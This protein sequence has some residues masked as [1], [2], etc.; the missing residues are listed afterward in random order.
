MTNKLTTCPPWPMGKSALRKLG[1]KKYRQAMELF[2][3]E[4]SASIEDALKAG[5]NFHGLVH[6]SRVRTRDQDQ[7]IIGKAEELNILPVELQTADLKVMSGLTTP[8]PVIG[9]AIQLTDNKPSE[10]APGELVLALDRIN[11]PGNVGSLLRTAAFYGIRQVW[12]GEESAELYNPKTIRAA[13]SSQFYLNIS[14]QVKLGDALIEAKSNGTEI[15][16]TVVEDGEPPSYIGTDR[17]Y[18]LVMG[19]EAHGLGDEIIEMAD[20]KVTI[21]RKN[22]IDSLNVAMSGAVLMDRLLRE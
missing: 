16:A 6:D 18:I 20:R 9:I 7:N 13:M 2:L 11:D 1:Q 8:P 14:R 19:N 4:G 17:G 21:P 5:A 22:P 12:L 3:V 10:V 15:I